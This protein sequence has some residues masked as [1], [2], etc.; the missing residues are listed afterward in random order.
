MKLSAFAFV[1]LFN[2]TVVFGQSDF[3]P[4]YLINHQHDTISGFINYK[5]RNFEVCIFKLG[6]V[7]ASTT[8]L[9]ESIQ[10]YWFENDK[11]FESRIIN[12]EDSVRRVF[13]EVL[14]RGKVSLYYYKNRFFVEKDGVEFHELESEKK[15]VYIDGKVSYQQSTKYMGLLTYLLRECDH[16]SSKIAGGKIGQKS[17][18]KLIEAYNSCV[19]TEYVSYKDSKPWTKISF[20]VAASYDL[21]WLDFNITYTNYTNYLTIHDFQSENFSIGGFLDIAS[22]RINERISFHPELWYVAPRYFVYFEEEEYLYIERNEV[23]VNFSAVKI[24][25]ALRYTFPFR[26]FTPFLNAGMTN[27]L[28]F[29]GESKRILETENKNTH[30]ITTQEDVPIDVGRYQAGIYGGMGIHYALGQKSTLFLETRYERGNKLVH[31]K[32]D[33]NINVLKSKMATLSILLG[34]NF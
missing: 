31:D 9:P 23:F 12:V 7:N 11:Y 2:V 34:I 24:P 16:L 13:L 14:V 8:Y 29:N 33:P 27:Y 30:T 22:P 10:A 26:K 20:G 28:I 17:L 19:S 6:Q 1:M 3:R 32:F 15:E 4:G 5:E 21:S 18:T 25:M